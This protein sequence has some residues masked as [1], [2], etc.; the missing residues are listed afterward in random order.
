MDPGKL[1]IAWSTTAP[2]GVDADPECIEAVHKAAKLCE[3]LGHGVGEARPVADYEAM[4]NATSVI[5]TANTAN[6]VD[7]YAQS[8]GITLDENILETITLFMAEMGRTTTASMY[9]GA[10]LTMHRVS[11]EIAAFYQDYDIL[12]TPALLK[13]P[14]PLGWLD[15]N[16][17]DAESYMACM[18][19]Y[20]GFT[21]L[22]NATG[23]P[24]VSLPLHW[25]NNNLPIG[26]LF[27]GRMGEESLLLQLGHQLEQA[28][29]WFDLRPNLA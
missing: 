19:A 10:L 22:Y 5:I 16:N 25:G 26:T 14:A 4:G 8:E 11:R 17:P 18:N 6:T 24:S 3:S 13:P 7:T 15:M 23:Q 27:T 28:A 9:A 2:T 29:P 12:I 1:R 21:A 20:F